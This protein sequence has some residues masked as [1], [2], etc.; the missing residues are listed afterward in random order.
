[1]VVGIPDEEWGQ[2]IEAAVVLRRGATVEP[3][4]LRQHV[5][6]HLRGS[7]TPDRILVWDQV[8]RSDLGKII[9]REAVDQILGH[10]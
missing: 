8:P 10:V 9:R 2:H 1:M 7:K 3:E 4:Q 5:R 6:A